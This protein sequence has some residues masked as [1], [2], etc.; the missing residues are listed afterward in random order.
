MALYVNGTRYAVAL[1]ANS[2]PDVFAEVI[3]MLGT[4]DT[5]QRNTSPEEAYKAYYSEIWFN[6]NLDKKQTLKEQND[7]Y[8]TIARFKRTKKIAGGE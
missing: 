1:G 3:P 4:V 8:I 6:T 7:L 2:T 5:I